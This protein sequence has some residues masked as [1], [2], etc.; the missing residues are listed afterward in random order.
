MWGRRRRRRKVLFLLRQSRQVDIMYNV[1][2]NTQGLRGNLEKTSVGRLSETSW[3]WTNCQR[4]NGLK[5][6]QKTWCTRSDKSQIS[7]VCTVQN[8][9][10]FYV[11][12]YDFSCGRISWKNCCVCIRP[13]N[14]TNNKCREYLCYWRT[15]I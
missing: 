13:N 7:P 3:D 8:F 9:T 4:I 15:L 12:E 2:S 6:V 11:Y 10:Q 14:K 1:L 5:H